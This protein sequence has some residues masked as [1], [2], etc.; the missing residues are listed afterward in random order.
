M[1]LNVCVCV[2]VYPHLLPRFR[3]L[4]FYSYIL[5]ITY[6]VHFHSFWLAAKYVI[7]LLYIY[8]HSTYSCLLTLFGQFTNSCVDNSSNISLNCTYLPNEYVFGRINSAWNIDRK[9]RCNTLNI[10]II[11]IFFGHPT[12]SF[13]ITDTVCIY[14]CIEQYE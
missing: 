7:L 1:T 11:Y 5:Y 8:I 4:R 14:V 10:Y 13:I 6:S 9:K 2:C 3:C 12:N